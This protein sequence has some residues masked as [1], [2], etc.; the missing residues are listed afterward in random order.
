MIKLF[1]EYAGEALMWAKIVL[2]WVGCMFGL[3]AL[4]GIAFGLIALGYR[5]GVGVFG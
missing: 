4:V 1:K 3:G 2:L 5:M